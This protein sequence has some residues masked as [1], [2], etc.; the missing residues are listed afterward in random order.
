[1]ENYAQDRVADSSMVEM[2]NLF[3]G[4][5]FLHIFIRNTF[6][7]KPY[8]IVTILW[9]GHLLSLC[10]KDVSLLFISY[11]QPYMYK[12]TLQDAKAN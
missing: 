3:Q 11:A 9:P 10:R 12:K 4:F 5:N 1:M 6:S 7:L 8:L 2:V